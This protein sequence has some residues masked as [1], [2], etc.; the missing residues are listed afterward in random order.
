[1][2]SHTSRATPTNTRTMSA[3]NTLKV[4]LFFAFLSSLLLSAQASAIQEI[5]R[6]A[7]GMGDYDYY[8]PY[9]L[10]YK[11]RA[12]EDYY[13]PPTIFNQKRADEDYLMQKRGSICLPFGFSCS[14]KGIKCCN[15]NVECRCNLFNTNCKC[16]RGGLFG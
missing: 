11:K 7:Y 9:A 16:Q 3:Q 2:G 4:V 5:K 6:D 13:N 8:N 14:T 12:D 10:Q 15:K 1:M